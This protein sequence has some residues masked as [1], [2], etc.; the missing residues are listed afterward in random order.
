MSRLDVKHQE[1]DSCWQGDVLQSSSDGGAQKAESVNNEGVEQSRV[2]QSGA[3][4]SRAERSRV[5]R[6]GMHFD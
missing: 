4:R 3:K 1:R 2:E 5:E 6:A